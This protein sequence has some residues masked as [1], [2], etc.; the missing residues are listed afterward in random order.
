MSTRLP[1]A[2]YL[3][4]FSIRFSNT[5]SSSSRSPSTISGSAGASTSTSTLAVARQRLQ[6]VDHLADDGDEIDRRVGPQMRVELDARQRQQ[7]VDQPR[8]ARGLRLHDAEEALARRGSSRAGPCSV[9]MK[10]DSAAS[11]VRS[12]WLALATK[13]ARISSTRR[14]GVRSWNVISTRPR[15]RLR[16]RAAQRD[17]RHDRL[18]PA[19]ERHALEELDP[20]RARRSRARAGSRRA[21]R[22]CAAPSDT[23]S[24]RRSAGAIARAGAFAASTSP[25]TS[26]AITGSGSPASTASSSGIAPRAARLLDDRRDQRRGGDVCRQ[27]DRRRDH[28]ERGNRRHRGQRAEQPQRAQHD[29]RGAKRQRA[30]SRSAA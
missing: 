21:L 7:V 2:P 25:W 4:A 1:E 15:R 28:D 16:R 13:S 6:A 20:L 18:V 19:V 27:Q 22:A 10:P 11:G 24:P 17:R 12:S 9:S 29:R 8:H 3:S 14:S 5:R 23:G 26:S 30:R